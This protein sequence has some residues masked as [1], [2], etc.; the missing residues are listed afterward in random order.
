M[1]HYYAHHYICKHVTQVLAKYCPSANL[2]Q[3]PCGKR[4]IWQSI[5]MDEECEECAAVMGEDRN[6]NVGEGG[7]VVAA[8]KVAGRKVS[9]GSR[10]VV[11]KGR[12]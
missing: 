9:V 12:R 6:G 8:S 3:T 11:R 10:R 1:C 7:R 5:R 4:E 2:V